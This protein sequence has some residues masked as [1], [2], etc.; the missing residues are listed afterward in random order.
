MTTAIWFTNSWKRLFLG[1]AIAISQHLVS[2]APSIPTANKSQNNMPEKIPLTG[3]WEF[4]IPP[5]PVNRTSLSLAPAFSEKPPTNPSKWQEIAVPSNWY[6][7]GYEISGVAWYRYRFA[8]DSRLAGKMVQLVFD[9]VDYTA[10]V[11]LNGR[12]LGFHEGYFQSFRFDISKYLRADPENELLVRV[13]SPKEIESQDWSLHKRL[14]KGVLSHHDARPGG[15]WSAKA[16]DRNTGGIWAPVYLKVSEKVAIEQVKI[17]PQVDIHH[18]RGVAEVALNLKFAEKTPKTVSLQLQLSPDN[19]PGVAYN[20]QTTTVRLE[21]GLNQVKIPVSAENPHLWET[22]E[23][24]KPNLYVLTVQAR[25]DDRLLDEAKATFG[26]RTIDFDDRERVW[27]LNGKRLFVRGT[28]YIASQWLSEMTPDKYQFDLELMKRAN[29][30]AVRVHAHVTGRDFYDLSD[31]AGILVWQDFPLQWGY[32]E[33]PRFATEAVKQA[34]DMVD[35]LYNHPSIMA[36]SLHNEPP[37]D[38]TW[39][40]YKYKSYNSQLNRSLDRHLYANLRDFDRTRYLHPYSSTSEHPWWGWYSN[41]YQKYAEPT[42]EPTITEFGAQALPNLRSLRYI[43]DET[44]LFPDTEAKWQKWEYHNFQRHETFDLAK[45]PMGNNPEEFV[46]NTQQYQ[47][48]LIKFA[49]E[50][51]RRQRYQPVASIFQFMFVECW[52]SMN[53]GIVDYW[54]NPKPGYTALQQAY[55]PILPLVGNPPLSTFK[56]GKEIA[57]DLWAINDLWKSFPHSKL[58]Y[59][60]LKENRLVQTQTIAI[61]LNPDSGGRISRI[62]YPPLLAGRYELQLRISDRQNNV[63]GQN[64]YSFEAIDL[65]P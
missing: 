58:T 53:W 17:T 23:R 15:A 8:G 60:L 46:N 38:A 62:V 37:W 65:I 30:N 20:I 1:L 3:K 26:F 56:S 45:V 36:W 6:L 9:G 5:Q 49:A 40:K 35:L 39:M 29:I 41:T 50:A 16:Q 32:T 24:G 12:Y 7:A 59:S 43:F 21:P 64:S 47:A 42:S 54:R 22:W 14:I 31:R 63:L 27:K 33:D 13:N 55:Q 34:K 2:A 11:W 25:E 61:D 52:A 10:D 44:E 51:Y 19:F 28:N 18:H 48:N 57:F 4:A